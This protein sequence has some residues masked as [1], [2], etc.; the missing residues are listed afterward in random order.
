MLYSFVKQLHKN[1][2]EF[3]RFLDECNRIFIYGAG[4]G[5]VSS[6]QYLAEEEINCQGILVSK[7]KKTNDCFSGVPVYEFP[8]EIDLSDDD[9]IIVSVRESL[10]DEITDYLNSN[11][12]R[13]KVFY[14]TGSRSK[15]KF[16]DRGMYISCVSQNDGDYFDSLTELNELGI[17]YST[18]KAN[19]FLKKYEL[20]IRHFKDDTIALLELGIFNGSSLKMWR[21][22]FNN[23]VVYGVDIDERCRNLSEERIKVII[24]NLSDCSFIQQLKKI[25]PSII[26]DDASHMWSHQ[27]KAFIIL[28]ESLK[29]GGIYI[30][31]DIH[32]SF[33]AIRD[34]GYDDASLSSYT[35]LCS[36]QEI[37]TS[38]EHLERSTKPYPVISLYDEIERIAKEIDMMTF[39]RNSCIIIK[40]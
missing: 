9:G 13:G 7:G 11:C 22:Y 18:D 17:K 36:L 27:I 28:W 24:G 39:I 30:M 1:R 37:V 2:L 8:S 34:W 33:R 31:E 38:G 10:L 32:T 26:V 20:F 29:S 5:A 35:F 19:L 12:F 23:A 6:L 3:L 14:H 15:H 4:A 40:K 16:I 25:E 21:D